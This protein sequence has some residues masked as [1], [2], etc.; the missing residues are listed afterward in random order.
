MKTITLDGDTYTVPSNWRELTPNQVLSLAK[1]YMQHKQLS[2]LKVVFALTLM[3]LQVKYSNPV[4]IGETK[5]YYVKHQSKR[6][7]LLSIDQILSIISE[8]GWLFQSN[9]SPQGVQ[10]Y[11][12]PGLVVNPVRNLKVRFSS[13]RGPDDGLTGISFIEFMYAE[14]FLYRYQKTTDPHWLNMFIATLWRPLRKG[15]TLPFNHDKLEQWAKRTARVKPHIAMAIMW[16]YE[17]C[18]HFISTQF[19]DVFGGGGSSKP[20]DPFKNY[21]D[22]T[23]TLAK[24]DPTKMEQVRQ[25]N[26]YDTLAGLQLMIKES[27]KRK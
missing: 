6:V 24:A 5:I 18:K 20:T 13:L 16:Y 9:Y 14:T 15:S 7:Y 11:I 23:A 27:E 4:T 19:P 8:F 22:L 2:H 12:N 21:M 10:V 25:A 3:G 26:L 1:I 17:G